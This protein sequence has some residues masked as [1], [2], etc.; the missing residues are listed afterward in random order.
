MYF[1]NKLKVY[2]LFVLILL[3]S[4]VIYDLV[5]SSS[6]YTGSSQNGCSCHGSNSSNTSIT[7][8]SASGSFSVKAG[9]TTEITVRVANSSQSAAGA[10]ITVKDGSGSNAGSFTAGSGLKTSG[11]ELTHDG[12]QDFVGGGFDFK[13]SW[14]APTTAGE[15]T[16]YAA[17]NAVNKNSNTGGDV[18]NINSQKIIVKGLTVSD[19]NGGELL[20]A[21]GNKTIT[22]TQF[23]V[24]AIKIDLVKDRTVSPI[25][26]STQASTGSYSWSIPAGIEAGSDYKI[27]ITDISDN[28]ITDESNATFTIG[29]P[30]TINTQPMTQASCTKKQVSFSVGASGTGLTYKWFKDNSELA[31]QVA[32]T[33]NVSNLKISDGGKYKVEVKNSC[34]TITSNEATLTV[35]QGPEFLTQPSNTA[36]CLNASAMFSAT[37]LGGDNVYQWQKDGQNIAGANQLTYNI[38]SVKPTDAGKYKLIITSAQ[39]G[40]LVT[41]QEATLTINATTVIN[42]QPQSVETCVDEKVVFSVAAVGGSL[43]FV[44]K[45]NGVD[46][47]NSN[48]TDYTIDKVKSTD[49]GDYTCTVIGQCGEPLTSNIAKLTIGNGPTISGQPQSKTAS[50]GSNVTFTVSSSGD[51]T[52]QW[53]KNNVNLPGTDGEVLFLNNVQTTDAG[54]YDCIVTNSCGS[55]FSSI[56]K[57]TISND[58]TGPVITLKNTNVVFADT[59]VGS[60]KD[61][62]LVDFI[63]NTGD[64]E[65]IINT[66]RVVPELSPNDGDFVI[67]TNATPYILQKGEKLTVM[68]RFKP[69]AAGNREVSLRFI[70]NA[71]TET[72]KLTGN[73]IEDSNPSVSVTNSN[74]VINTIPGEAKS[75]KIIINNTGNTPVSIKEL[76]RSGNNAELTTDA[77]FPLDINTGDSG[78]INVNFNPTMAVNLA[79]E[80]TIKFTNPAI[81]DVKININAKAEVASINFI[82]LKELTTYPNPTNGEFNVKFS[83][84]LTQN[85]NFEII[86]I[87]GNKVNNILVNANG[88]G[89]YNLNWNGTNLNGNKVGAGVYFGRL[90]GYGVS[91]TVKFT[92]K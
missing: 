41:S 68:L 44:W 40:D 87:N 67:V 63:E 16:I 89:E 50:V 34:G 74:I 32:A 49:A 29:G 72:I 37:A 22:W 54:D 92:I 80:W 28:T 45:K 51:N 43:N 13:F 60:S 59:K 24:S 70:T 21:G 47:P 52:Y 11:G 77:T 69:S 20:C 8:T 84:D 58:P 1:S 18:P 90:I 23:G 85:I 65:L 81:A 6:G 17:G 46:L 71:T 35:N 91:N 79:E 26:A 25:V 42:T 82:E 15:Y 19:P 48:K 31:G 56:A 5:S 61:S 36:A 78:E 3:S 38:P 75:D 73:G 2:T 10:N 30:P 14:T 9:S 7:F 83:A 12:R 53:R 4:F 86:D 62:S 76:I 27:R 66:I 88:F 39:C 55:S 57:L 33:L 64:A